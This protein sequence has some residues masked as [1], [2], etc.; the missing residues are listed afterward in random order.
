MSQYTHHC[1]RC[2]VDIYPTKKMGRVWTCSADGCGAPNSLPSKWMP[3]QPV[4]CRKCRTQQPVMTLEH[5][6]VPRCPG[7]G[8]EDIEPLDPEPSLQPRSTEARM[9]AAKSAD[10]VAKAL[11]AGIPG[12]D[13][14]RLESALAWMRERSDTLDAEIEAHERALADLRNERA[15]IRAILGAV[16]STEAPVDVAQVN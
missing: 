12:T 7:C 6:F 3:E 15:R 1:G 11:K 9:P 8:N 16:D 13:F 4:V 2:Q 10:T 14:D 5:G